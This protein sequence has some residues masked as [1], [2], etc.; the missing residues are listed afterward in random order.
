MSAAAKELE[1]VIARMREDLSSL[2]RAHEILTRQ[3]R[4]SMADLPS[5]PP[6]GA[7]HV[8][9]A[10]LVREFLAD[11]SPKSTAEIYEHARTALPEANYKAVANWLTRAAE[12]GDIKKLERGQFALN[13]ADARPF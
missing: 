4:D 1:A 9:L 11:G 6:A 12:R 8:N 7:A 13:D 5:T 3:A 10:G 2:E